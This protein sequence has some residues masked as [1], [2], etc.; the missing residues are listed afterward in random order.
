MNNFE[1]LK[2]KLLPL[3]DSNI[4]NNWL[5]IINEE[6]IRRFWSKID[7]NAVIQNFLK[8]HSQLPKDS[9][10][11]QIWTWKHNIYYLNHRR[12]S[13]IQKLALSEKWRNELFELQKQFESELINTLWEF[14]LH[15]TSWWLKSVESILRK[16]QRINESWMIIT[17]NPLKD[18]RD[19]IRWRI[20]CNSLRDV[21]IAI[22]LITDK[23][24]SRLVSVLNTYD[25]L[26]RRWQN[27]QKI[28]KPYLWCNLTLGVNRD[29][30]YEIQLM[31]NRASIIWAFNHPVFVEKIIDL[32]EEL[33]EYLEILCFWSHILDIEEFSAQAVL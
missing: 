23:F 28:A 33:Q 30:T 7:A 2:A 11:I 21:D 9:S 22:R 4:D 15:I 24:W 26:F 5:E 3:C 13:K 17:D 8:L 6:I 14:W 29:I 20:I 18:I 25:T 16:N 1:Q 31:T 19:Y 10:L 32:E 12:L 27:W